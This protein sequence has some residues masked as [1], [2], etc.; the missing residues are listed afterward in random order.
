MDLRGRCFALLVAASVGCATAKDAPPDVSRRREN[1]GSRDE[2]KPRA[3]VAGL[4]IARLR[5]DFE[6]TT[7]DEVRAQLGAGRVYESG[8]AGDFQRELCMVL[9][10][11]VPAT[12]V[13]LSS[14]MGG[15]AGTV[16]GVRL[17]AGLARSQR[18]SPVAASLEE[19]GLDGGLR[20]GMPLSEIRRHWGEGRALNGGEI[21][22]EDS[23][24][25]FVPDS[26]GPTG[27]SARRLVYVSWGVRLTVERERVVAIHAWQVS[28]S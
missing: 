13:L 16:T 24:D 27:D 18:C 28:T 17:S 12:L 5:I 6:R 7:L 2:I 9:G 25:V 14:E 4:F 10:G 26:A 19:V 15:E 8:D 11:S 3:R 22:F 21:M 23:A 1:V 20:L